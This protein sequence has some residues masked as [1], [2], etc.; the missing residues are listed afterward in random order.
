M[1]ALMIVAFGDELV[2]QPVPVSCV[3]Y[4]HPI[5]A[6]DG[7]EII[8]T[9]SKAASTGWLIQGVLAVVAGRGLP[10]AMG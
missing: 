9:G 4:A 8:R 5:A 6:C 1:C 10:Y 3:C 2:A 7:L